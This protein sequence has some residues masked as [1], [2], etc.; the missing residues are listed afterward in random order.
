LA[1]G[2]TPVEVSSMT[3]RHQTWLTDAVAGSAMLVVLYF[4]L[5]ELSRAR[6]P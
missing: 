6:L 2:I 1:S 5:L 3:I 4:I